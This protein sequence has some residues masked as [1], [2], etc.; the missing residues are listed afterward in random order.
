[1]LGGGEDADVED[2]GVIVPSRRWSDRGPGEA[3]VVCL[4]SVV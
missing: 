3:G 2:D 4:E 1:M